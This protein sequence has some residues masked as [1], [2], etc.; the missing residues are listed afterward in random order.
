MEQGQI[1]RE[2]HGSGLAEPAHKVN[3]SALDFLDD[4]SD[5]G[6]LDRLGI[7]GGQIILELLNGFT[8]SLD[9]TDKRERSFSVRSHEDDLV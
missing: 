8:C 9:L 6:A 5:G 7:D 4:D 1:P 3:G 2:L